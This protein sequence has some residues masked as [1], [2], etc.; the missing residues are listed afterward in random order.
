MMTSGLSLLL[1]LFAVIACLYAMAGFGGGS[2]YIALLAISGLPMTAIP[3][4][5]LSCNLLVSSQGGWLLTR[6]GHAR[7]AI[8]GPLLA[9][10]M[11]SAFLGGAWRL[12]PEAFLGILASALTLAGFAML[13]QNFLL[14]REYER[15]DP[16]P[17]P[18]PL[19][20]IT[21]VGLGLVAG[22][23]GIGGGIYLAPVMHLLGWAKAHTI[24]SCTSL[25]IAFN[26]LAGLLGQLSKGPSVI[27]STP[28]ALWIACPCA[29]VVGGRLGSYLL[30]EKLPRRRVEMV[31]A[32]VILIVAVRLWLKAIS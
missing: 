14:R 28:L 23:T 15:P 25:F 5:A 26:S 2:T 12:P 19:L 3:V 21:G 6:R 10:S 27:E 16:K 13:A 18:L 29:V 32:F 31:T 30:T 22:I 20:A 4:L 8:V 9:G 17:P 7:W 11:P 1:F 24:A